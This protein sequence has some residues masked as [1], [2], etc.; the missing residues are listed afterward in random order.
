MTTNLIAKFVRLLLQSD[1]ELFSHVCSCMP[2]VF[3]KQTI[4]LIAEQLRGL[5]VSAAM[6]SRCDNTNYSV[7]CF[8]TVQRRYTFRT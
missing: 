4:V 5:R 7:G 1:G 6:P 2:Q 3:D 8:I